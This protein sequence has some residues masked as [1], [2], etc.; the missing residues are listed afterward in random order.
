[1]QSRTK[2]LVGS[3]QDQKNADGE[4]TLDKTPSTIILGIPFSKHLYT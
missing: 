3:N 2:S 1:M 4:S